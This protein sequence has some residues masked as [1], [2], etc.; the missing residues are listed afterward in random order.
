MQVVVLYLS[1]GLLFPK[2]GKIRLFFWNLKNFLYSDFDIKLCLKF[3]LFMFFVLSQA[4]MHIYYQ[5]FLVMSIFTIFHI[6]K[7]FS[8]IFIF[9]I[10]ILSSAW[11][12]IP[13]LFYGDISP[14]DIDHWRHLGTFGIG[15][16]NGFAGETLINYSSDY[17][18]IKNIFV[19]FFPGYF[20]EFVSFFSVRCI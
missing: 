20:F 15:F 17:N 12:V 5:M 2:K 8:L 11:Y 4:D 13:V 14:S 6:K 7:Y 10:S 19:S 1:L 18:F 9:L 16:A 3:S